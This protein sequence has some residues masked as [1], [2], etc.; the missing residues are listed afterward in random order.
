MPIVSNTL[1]TEAEI[2]ARV[3]ALAREIAP[4]IDDETVLVCLLTGGIWFAADLTRALPRLDRDPM[5]DCLWLASYG[6]DRASSGACEVRAGLQR[7][8]TGRKVLIIDDVFDSGLSLS[9]AVHL[10]QGAG[11]VEALTAVFARKPWSS[12]RA[13]EPDF[14]GWEAPAQF[15]AGYGMDDAGRGRGAPGIVSVKTS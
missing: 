13:V 5:F 15:L 7:D 1:L 8:V 11:A 14:V 2:A 9:Q 12:P 3:E 10:V 4:R 6:D